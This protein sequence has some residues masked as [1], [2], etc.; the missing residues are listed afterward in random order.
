MLTVKNIMTAGSVDMRTRGRGTHLVEPDLIVDPRLR[1][2][3]WP[4]G[5]FL[6]RVNR[7]SEILRMC[8]EPS[9]GAT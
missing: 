1:L 7:V 6:G 3:P 2:M 4:L 5:A 9:T 8:A